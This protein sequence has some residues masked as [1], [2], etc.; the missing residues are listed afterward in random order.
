MHKAQPLGSRKDVGPHEFIGSLACVALA[1]PRDA[2]NKRKL[3]AVAHHGP[4]FASS[5]ADGPSVETR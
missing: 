5:L 2:G 1:Q 3:A 4:A